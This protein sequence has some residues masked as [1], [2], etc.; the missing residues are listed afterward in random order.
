MSQSNAAGEKS[1][2]G[3][4]QTALQGAFFHVLREQLEKGAVSH[5]YLFTGPTGVGKKTMARHFANMLF[6]QGQQKPCGQCGPCHQ[7]AGGNHPDF[8]SVTGEKSIGVDAIRQAIRLTGEHTYQ[9][10][11]RV[12]I[13]EEAQRMTPQAQNT[14]LKTLEEPGADIVFLLTA[15][16]PSL[17]L[18]TV[19]SRCRRIAVTPLPAEEIAGLLARRGVA[20][21]RIPALVSMAQGCPGIALELAED[22]DFTVLRQRVLSALWS[23]TDKSAILAVSNTFKDDKDQGD[24][25]L[26]IIENAIR[27]VLQVRLGLAPRDRIATYPETWKKAGQ[28]A[29]VGSLLRLMEGIT[30]SRQYRASQVNWQAVLEKLLLQ[31]TEEYQT[32]QQ[33]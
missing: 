5:A 31:I 33:L 22:G 19:V 2:P 24:K 6:C 14:L 7:F 3:M 10:G 27:E 11:R 18:P 15:T 16:D 4:E 26:A 17:L 32:W 8:L 21:E 20:Q 9:G 29:P 12:I 25:V 23:L 1:A 28:A 30:A 13:I